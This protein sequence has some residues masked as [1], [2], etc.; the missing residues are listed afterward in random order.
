MN[1][2]QL[3]EVRLAHF[4]SF[5]SELPAR[6]FDPLLDHKSGHSVTT[7]QHRPAICGMHK[8]SPWITFAI[9]AEVTTPIGED[10][11]NRRAKQV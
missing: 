8:K 10:A 2:F 1:F 4:K 5:L 7:E 6:F 3:S 11:T 9:F